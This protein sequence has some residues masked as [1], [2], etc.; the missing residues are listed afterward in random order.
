MTVDCILHLNQKFN[1]RRTQLRLED[2][3]F[4][5]MAYAEKGIAK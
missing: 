3:P 2:V 5:F 4:R 1:F